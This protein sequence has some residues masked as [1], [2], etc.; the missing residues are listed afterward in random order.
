MTTT[1]LEIRDRGTLIPA[2]AITIAGEDDPIARHAGFGERRLVILINLVRLECQYDPFAWSATGRTMKIAHLW[3]EK[4]LDALEPGAV[5]D[6]EYLLDER[7]TPK[8]A[9]IRRPAA[10]GV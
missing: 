1:Y 10:E 2:L 5:V 9:E 4:H 3:I 7:T 8:P 6:V